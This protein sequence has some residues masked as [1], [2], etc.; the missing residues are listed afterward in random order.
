MDLMMRPVRPDDWCFLKLSFYITFWA[1][2]MLALPD[3]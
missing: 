1:F 2:V 3:L